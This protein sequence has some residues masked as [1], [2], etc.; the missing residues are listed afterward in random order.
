MSLA[1][2]PPPRPKSEGSVLSRL[3]F[4]LAMTGRR[5][6]SF[7]SPVYPGHFKVVLR[8]GWFRRRITAK[9]INEG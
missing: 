3:F 7:P 8:R 9:D 1:G 2:A 6:L 5:H 4:L